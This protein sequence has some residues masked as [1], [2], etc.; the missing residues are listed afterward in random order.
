MDNLSHHAW[1]LILT[2]GRT[3]TV[4]YHPNMPFCTACSAFFET[5]FI[6][7]WVHEY[8]LSL[9]PGMEISSVLH[10]CRTYGHVKHHLLYLQRMWFLFSATSL[11]SVWRVDVLCVIDWKLQMNPWGEGS[12]ASHFHRFVSVGRH[13]ERKHWAV[14]RKTCWK[15]VNKL[16]LDD[17]FTLVT[18]KNTTL[19]QIFLLFFFPVP[20]V[21][22]RQ[23][24]NVSCS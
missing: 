8:K 9:R 17:S 3:M 21:R 1:V 4:V 14:L 19:L 11:K 7:L 10:R 13:G 24:L 15:C 6:F 18:K 5:K 23:H 22:W 2:N 12:W 16:R 20:V